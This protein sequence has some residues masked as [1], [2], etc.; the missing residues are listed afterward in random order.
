M[1][2]VMVPLARYVLLSVLVMPVSAMSQQPPTITISPEKLEFPAHLVGAPGEPQTLTLSNTGA[3]SVPL[4]GVLISGIDFSQTNDCG[5]KLGA[6]A[7]CSVSITFKPAVTGTRLG[8]IQ[9]SWSGAG[10]PRTIPLTG[11]SQ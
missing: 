9:L 2:V 6:G 7:K 8:A 3:M 10:S 5:E 1:G 4:R 11:L